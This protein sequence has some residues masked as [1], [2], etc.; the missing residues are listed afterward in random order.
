MSLGGILFCKFFQVQKKER[1][2][3]EQFFIPFPVKSF[4]PPFLDLL[5][6]EISMNVHSGSYDFINIEESTRKQS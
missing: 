5:S 1:K 2:K 4:W 6:C 3:N